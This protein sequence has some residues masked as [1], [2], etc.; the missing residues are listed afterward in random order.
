MCE[1][2][3]SI[4]P[5]PPSATST[6]PSPASQGARPGSEPRGQGAAHLAL[7]ADDGAAF[8]LGHKHASVANQQPGARLSEVGDVADGLPLP[9]EQLYFC[10][11]DNA[12]AH[13]DYRFREGNHRL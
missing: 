12:S 8:R 11:V 13:I 10:L 6:L 4:P 9:A 7:D 1:C 2:D 5:V 3:R